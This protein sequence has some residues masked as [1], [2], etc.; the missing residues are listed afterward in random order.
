[1]KRTIFFLVLCFYTAVFAG[2]VVTRRFLF[3][4]NKIIELRVPTAWKDNADQ[5]SREPVPTINFQPKGRNQFDVLLSPLPLSKEE[6]G[7]LTR[8]E[9]RKR[10]NAGADAARSQSVEKTVSIVELKS[11]TGFGYYYSVTDRAPGSG[12]YKYMTQ[13]MIRIGNVAVSFTILTNDHQSEVVTSALFMIG[14][15]SYFEGI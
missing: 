4:P 10:V 6:A 11:K 2:D 1:M 5:M 9:V 7:L 13:G 15:A 14:T 12:E 3:S 8:E